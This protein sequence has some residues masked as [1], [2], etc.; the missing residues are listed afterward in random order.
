MKI[1]IIVSKTLVDFEN[2]PTP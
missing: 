1:L 2:H